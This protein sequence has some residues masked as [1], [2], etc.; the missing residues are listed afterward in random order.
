MA[1]FPVLSRNPSY[2][3]EEQH[4]ENTIRSQFEAGYEQTRP[5]FTRMRKTFTLKYELMSSTDK[6]AVEN[7]YIQ[8][9][10]GAGSFSWTHPLTNNTHT[11]RFAEPP[12]FENVVRDFW[13]IT[14]KLREV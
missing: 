13:N 14:I 1:N 10:G 2:P 4:E 3:F 7:F 9:K 11:V 6:E 8:Q 12:K 5:R